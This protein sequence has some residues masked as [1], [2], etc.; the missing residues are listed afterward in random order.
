MRKRRH[1]SV[2]VVV[3]EFPAIFCRPRECRRCA[4][5][6]EHTARHVALSAGK[7]RISV[8]PTRRRSR[9][10][11][12]VY[13]RIVA[14]T[15]TRTRRSVAGSEMFATTMLFASSRTTAKLDRVRVRLPSGWFSIHFGR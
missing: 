4:E 3:A 1:G 12:V 15:S 8:D 5:S 14:M 2:E 7:A 13:L 9:P 6:D 11:I 10:P